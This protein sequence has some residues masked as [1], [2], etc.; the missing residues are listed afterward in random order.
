MTESI[1]SSN[2]LKGIPP[3]VKLVEETQSPKLKPPGS[4]IIIE[5]L[6][7][8]EGNDIFGQVEPEASWWARCRN[9]ATISRN[10]MIIKMRDPVTGFTKVKRYDSRNSS[11][12]QKDLQEIRTLFQNS[13]DD[14]YFQT[15]YASNLSNF[16]VD[17]SFIQPYPAGAVL[18]KRWPNQQPGAPIIKT[19]VELASLFE[20]ETPGLWHR[21]VLNILLE[22]PLPSDPTGLALKKK[23]SPPRQALIWQALDTAISSALFAVWHYKWLAS[24]LSQ[25]GYRERP[26]EADNSLPVLYDYRVE[27]PNGDIVRTNLKTNPEEGPQPSPGTPRHPAYGSGHSTYAAAAS[28]V[29]G[30]LLPDYKVDFDK[31]ANNIGEARIWGGVHWRGDHEFGQQLGKAVGELIIDQLNRSGI[32]PMS[33]GNPAVPDRGLLEQAADNYSNTCGDVTKSF[34][35]QTLSRSNLQGAPG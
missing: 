22:L 11:Q 25:V 26:W 16:L 12:A 3:I 20:N 24:N 5:F 9:L 28:H 23:L 13:H 17:L 29:L 34:C 32:E 31:L 19:G 35:G 1:N 33:V 6:Y 27:Y 4:G 30:C 10:E 7:N 21:H 18:N 15:N 2:A 14:L 8:L